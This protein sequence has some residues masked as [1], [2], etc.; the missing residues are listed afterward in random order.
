LKKKIL[1]ITGCTGMIGKSLLRIL[2]KN[3]NYNLIILCKNNRQIKSL[4][5]MSTKLKFINVD[6]MQYNILKKKIKPYKNFYAVI[7]MASSKIEQNQN[8]EDHLNINFVLT[9][10]LLKSIKD[11]NVKHFIY[12]NTAAIY[13]PGFNIKESNE[14]GRNP[15]GLSKY[16]VS[17]FIE[18][19]CINQKI[20]FKDLRIFSVFGEYEKKNRLTAEA[21][22]CSLNNKN[23]FLKTPNQFRD[24]LYQ[25]DV[26]NAIIKSIEIK[27]NFSV[28]IC[29]EKKIGTHELVK[30]IFK[31]TSNTNLIKF[32]KINK[33]SKKILGK[34]T[35]N[36]KFAKKI[37]GWSPQYGIDTAINLTIKKYP[38]KLYE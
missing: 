10:N 36:N 22:H 9:L 16:I 7:H 12:T 1:L 26:A 11:I 18:N 31:K 20:F 38:K 14:I 8:F 29:S 35:G 27:K 17:K 25:D 3:I 15:Y 34:L 23:F 37:M 30:K 13:K 33:S 28:N 5:F 19:F 32:S 24:Y 2:S 4:K 21:I 6:L